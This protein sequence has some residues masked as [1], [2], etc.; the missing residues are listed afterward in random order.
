MPEPL[1]ELLEKIDARHLPSL[2]HVLLKLLDVCN[3]EEPTFDGICRVLD[4]DTA[5]AARIISVG[6][7][8]LYGRP[9]KITSLERA[10]IALGLDTVKTIA[11]SA[12]VYQVFSQIGGAAGL[13]LKRF[14]WHSLM[15]ATLS[16][17]IAEKAAYPAPDEAYLCGLLH[18]IGQLVLWAN[19]PKDYGSV[20]ED[21]A[22][23]TRLI[24]QEKARLGATHC[25][26]GAWLIGTWK[27]QSFIADAVLYHHDPMDRIVHAPELVKIVHLAD[28][29][30]DRSASAAASPSAVPEPLFGL[31]TD[32]I[33]EL[34]GQARETVAHIARSFE[35][36]PNHGIEPGPEEA[37]GELPPVPELPDRRRHRG[38]PERQSPKPP[39]ATPDALKRL[40]LTRAVR[41]IALLEGVHQNLSALDDSDG[42][43]TGIEKCLNILFGLRHPLFFL[44]DRARHALCGKDPGSQPSLVAELS[45]PLDSG[46]SLLSEALARR[47]PS[48]SFSRDEA[49]V[50]S[51]LDEQLIRL[52]QK[53]GILCLPMTAGDAVAGV[54]VCGVD[55][56]QMPRLEKQYRLIMMFARLCAR[57]LDSAQRR[58]AQAEA[59]GT[60]NMALMKAH[61]RKIAHE[62]NNP[63]N[64][65]KNYLQLL[66]DKL[67]KGDIEYGELKI[68][69]EEIDRVSA[70]VRELSALPP[71]M[72]P[73]EGAVDV[74]RVITELIAFTEGTLFAPR[75]IALQPR[76]G[77]A[78]PPLRIARGKLKQILLNL[79]KNAAEAMPGGGTLTV[80]TRNN[81]NRDGAP[82]VEILVQD[83][84]P[85]IPP[86][87]MACLFQPVTST[88]GGGHAGLGLS[89]VKE[90][91]G[92]LR[93]SITCSS[94]EKG[95]TTFQILLPKPEDS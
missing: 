38:S 72:H 67:D 44:Y 33:A 77:E 58:Q 88:K 61:T 83:S 54:I 71:A 5:L 70:L 86:Q 78:L 1:P 89:I 56:S 69:N 23:E 36:E 66:G 50:V 12:A 91:V 32:E 85:G 51:I 37:A 74:N 27:L 59:A 10:L 76:L 30:A 2:P 29:L 80:S 52:T 95:G 7:S 24:A 73:E 62:V 49:A 75:N 4:K 35:I 31:T 9:T 57:M 55:R 13:D 18:D 39:T 87:V 14:W 47:V 90:I 53:E 34:T 25:E 94:S 84:G 19:F 3:S 93:G 43:L 79:F 17:L 46:K 63:L 68:V 26:I 81:V 40:E 92:Q 28:S 65:M 22:D 48:E 60:E 8:P 20:M 16:R 42:I 21:E 45:V 64:I 82:C 15:C 11:I 41:D 6:N